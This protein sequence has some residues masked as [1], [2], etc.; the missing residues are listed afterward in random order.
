MMAIVH[1]RYGRPSLLK[2]GDLEKPA[3]EDD[4]MLVRVEASSVNPVEWY[5]VTGPYFARFGNGFRRPKDPRVGADFAGTVEAVGRI[6]GVL[7]PSAGSWALDS[8]GSSRY[9]GLIAA[10]MVMAFVALS[11]IRRHIP[12]ATP[13]RAAA[14]PASS[15]GRWV[16]ARSLRR[17]CRSCR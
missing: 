11:A 13:A 5:G 7:S 1:E 12:G 14:S 9:F 2:V 4:Q 15:R 3:P 16:G 8:G 17:R 6:G 10:A